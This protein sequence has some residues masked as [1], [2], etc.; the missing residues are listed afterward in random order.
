MELTLSTKLTEMATE[1]AILEAKAER[2]A[3]AEAAVAGARS[4][5]RG[6]SVI[7]RPRC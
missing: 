2:M 4:D 1:A 7:E 5:A 3:Q 6:R